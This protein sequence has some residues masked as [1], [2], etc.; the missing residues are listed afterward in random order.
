MTSYAELASQLVAADDAWDVVGPQPPSRVDDV[1]S[2]LSIR[3]PDSYRRYLVEV[4]GIEYP[5]HC[6]EGLGDDYLHPEYGFGRFTRILRED[7]DLPD[8]LFVIEHDHDADELVC[9]DLNQMHDGECPLVWF[10][11]Y[12]N[13]VTGPCEPTFDS[14][15]R[16]LV[17]SWVNM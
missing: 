8:G 2:K 4:G 3:L 10:H 5:N 7:N 14:F 15:F 12:E 9:I 13:V 11:V 16:N 17:D 6:Y 1:E